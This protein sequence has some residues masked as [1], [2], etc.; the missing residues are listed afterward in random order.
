MFV[1]LIT[2]N[3]ARYHEPKKYQEL[4]L[5]DLQLQLVAFF[6]LADAGWIIYVLR[7]KY[8]AVVARDVGKLIHIFDRHAKNRK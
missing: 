6:F 1:Y 3:D 7:I 8:S 4:L 5:L 2:I